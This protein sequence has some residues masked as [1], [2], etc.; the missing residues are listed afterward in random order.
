MAGS[1]LTVARL[2][3]LLGRPSGEAFERARQ[4]ADARGHPALRAIVD[5]DDGVARRLAREPGA[6]ALLASA[7]ERFQA[8]GMT[9]WTGRAPPRGGLP[10]GLTAREAEVLRLLAAGHTN[11]EI[12]GELVLSVF[13]VER[14]LANAYRKISVR[15]RAD[16]TAYVLR[17]E[18]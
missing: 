18:L 8:L 15:N 16:A 4:V 14:H 13:T 5:H 9:A 10:D 1:E 17:A 7:A 2:H 3:A 12:A 6:A 11:K